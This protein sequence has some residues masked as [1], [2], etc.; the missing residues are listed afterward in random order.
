MIETEVEHVFDAAFASAAVVRDQQLT[1][2]LSGSHVLRVK[3]AP[4]PMPF[5]GSSRIAAS[6][7]C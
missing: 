3:R 7:P 4:V 5:S 2:G 6:T 1:G